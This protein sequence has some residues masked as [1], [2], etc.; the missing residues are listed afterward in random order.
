MDILHSTMN[1]QGCGFGALEKP[2][3]ERCEK[4]HTDPHI[5]NGAECVFFCV[6]SPVMSGCRR[7]YN[8]GFA[9]KTG[10]VILFYDFSNTPTA[11]I[12]G[13][14]F[15]SERNESMEGADATE[16]REFFK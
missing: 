3:E 8:R 7:L 16:Y 2:I 5:E 1:S 12:C 15:L 6:I 14:C 10:G 11:S 9:P 13:G 4:M